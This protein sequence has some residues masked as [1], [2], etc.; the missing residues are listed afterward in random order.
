MVKLKRL[1]QQFKEIIERRRGKNDERN[2][3]I[4]TS[5]ATTARR[6]ALFRSSLNNCKETKS[7]GEML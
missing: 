1:K 4:M 3:R 5:T 7:E 2:R 6:L